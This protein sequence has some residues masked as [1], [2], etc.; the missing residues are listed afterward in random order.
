MPTAPATELEAGQETI[1]NK[2]NVQRL[3]K[4][5]KKFFF[6]KLVSFCYAKINFLIKGLMM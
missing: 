2:K 6:Q 1:I 5:K 4:K 3:K